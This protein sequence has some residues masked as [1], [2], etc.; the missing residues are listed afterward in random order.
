[1]QFSD[2]ATPAFYENPYPLYK[3]VRE[4]GR[5][6]PLAPGMSIT[7]HH[8]MVNA[9]LCDRR[10]GR[11]Y[12]QGVQL[13]YGEEAV[14]GPAFQAWSRMMLMLNPPAHTPLRAALMQAFNAR[15][16][17][18]FQHSVL[19][20]ANQLI[21]DI[22]AKGEA[23][24]MASFAMPLPMRVICHMLDVPYEDAHLFSEAARRLLQTLELVPVN[25]E[26]QEQAH[27]AA[28]QLQDYFQ[29]II[30][31]RKQQPGND[32]ISRLLNAA[33]EGEQLSEQDLIANVILLFLAGHET[34]ANMIGN[35][36]IAL[37]R[38]PEQWQALVQ[39]PALAKAA[40]PELLRYDSAV[41]LSA[42]VVLEDVEVQGHQLKAGQIL[43]LLLGSAN[44]DPAVFHSPDELNFQRP[45]EE[46]R[47]VSFGGG[48]HYCLGARLAQM[49]LH[50]A[51]QVL[52]SR[53][54]GLQIQEPKITDWH[55]R[56]TLR[57]VSTLK[58]SWQVSADLPEREVAEA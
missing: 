37:Q 4:S 54:P 7:G 30:T 14:N 58:A 44:R 15:Q 5:L 8:E 53:L 9:L 24:L 35:S 41:Q 45:I 6:L 12:L 22:L 16:M 51:L 50:L 43:Y 11:A 3:K 23:D 29:T 28:L 32:L 40:A 49:E 31:A 36:L 42:R 17:E 52:F 27:Q 20:I 26:Q 57:G 19:E 2:F 47:A 21:D 25:A 13:R 33:V 10:V 34:T 18:E 56:H 48:I 38:H 39:N 46:A 1:M 55:Q